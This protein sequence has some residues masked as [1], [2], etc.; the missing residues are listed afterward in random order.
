MNL[1][2]QQ[3]ALAAQREQLVQACAAQ[4]AQLA[5]QAEALRRRS[6]IA[7]LRTALTLWRTWRSTRP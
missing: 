5:A 7:M 3:S 1:Q 4:R 2:R 6:G